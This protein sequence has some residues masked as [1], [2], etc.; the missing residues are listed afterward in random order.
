MSATFA[1]SPSTTASAERGQLRVC[2][3]MRHAGQRQVDLRWERVGDAA[4]PAVVLAGGISG[5]RHAIAS[6][7]VSDAGWWQSQAHSFDTRR[8]SFISFD[9]L[10][11]DGQLDVPIDT[12][13][14][15]DALAAILDALHIQRLHAWLGN[16]YGAMVG[17]QFALR[18]APRLRQ[19]VAIS[20]AHRPHPFA[21]AW[22]AMQRRAVALGALQCDTASGLA[23]ARALAMLS[24]RTPEEFGERFDAPPTI[25]N[26][27]VRCAAEDYLDAAAAKWVARTHPT[28]FLRLSES[29]DLHSVN[30]ADV[31]VPTSVVAV[32][33]DRLVPPADSRA[34]YSGL[35]HPVEWHL[36]SSLFGHDAFLKEPEAIHAALQP[37]LA[38]A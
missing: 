31:Q 34:L 20:G 12:A 16:S 21:S 9:W 8:F 37:A 15:A 13:D 4:L 1:P 33:S 32:E 24:Y 26:N 36:L 18:H 3:P 29:I 11:V 5:N 2:L 22:R 14:Q 27:Q 38:T 28:A 7:D 17:L 30:P 23:L 25:D 6:A 35:P 19:L 10:G